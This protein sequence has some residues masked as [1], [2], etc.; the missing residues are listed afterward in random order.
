MPLRSA[1][2]ELLARAMKAEAA[3]ITKSIPVVN[4]AVRLAV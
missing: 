3:Q 2:V 1:A 4:Q